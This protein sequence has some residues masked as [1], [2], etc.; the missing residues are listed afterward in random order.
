[1]L[2]AAALWPCPSS[3]RQNKCDS[4]NITAVWQTVR[5][6]GES[7]SARS[8]CWVVQE[9]LCHTI[10]RCEDNG[11]SLGNHNLFEN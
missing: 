5:Q 9:Y 1:M 11:E 8:S 3:T 7:S 4:K 2:A 6:N 10:Q